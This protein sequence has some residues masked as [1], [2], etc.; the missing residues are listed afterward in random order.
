MRSQGGISAP[1]RGPESF[2]VPCFERKNG[3][4]KSS[5]DPGKIPRKRVPGWVPANK[6]SVK[7]NGLTLFYLV[8]KMGLEPRFILYLE[9]VSFI[10]VHWQAIS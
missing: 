2:S 3:S 6:K 7:P 9:K 1:G 8:R 10:F 4:R 5:F